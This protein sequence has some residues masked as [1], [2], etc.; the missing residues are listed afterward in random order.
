MN[1]CW[2]YIKYQ[3]GAKCFTC[4]KS[5][6]GPLRLGGEEETEG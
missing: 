4:I 1:L 3:E 5:Q 6:E 2:A